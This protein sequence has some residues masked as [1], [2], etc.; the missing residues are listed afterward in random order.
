M[1]GP[2]IKKKLIV[3]LRNFA[4]A[5]KNTTVRTNISFAIFIFPPVSF[6]VQFAPDACYRQPP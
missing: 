2:M 5:P 4:N 6:F 1:H 3:A